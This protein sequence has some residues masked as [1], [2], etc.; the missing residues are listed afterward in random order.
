MIG[1]LE[2]R[3]ALD[4]LVNRYSCLLDAFEFEPLCA[5][6]TTDCELDQR[7]TGTGHQRG[8]DEVRS[9]FEGLPDAIARQMHHVGTRVFDFSSSDEALGVV[10]ALAEAHSHGGGKLRAGVRYDDVY[11][12]E[13]GEWRIHRR[14]LSLLIPMEDSGLFADDRQQSCEGVSPCRS[15]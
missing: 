9:F 13:G 6:F 11:R 5:L 4:Q 1:T 15:F 2:D 10:Y 14:T 12:R 3:A 8:M 7:A